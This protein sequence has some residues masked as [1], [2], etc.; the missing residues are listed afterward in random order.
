MTPGVQALL[1]KRRITFPDSDGR[2]VHAFPSDRWVILVTPSDERTARANLEKILVPK[3]LT[4]KDVQEV[5]RTKDGRYAIYQIP[6]VYLKDARQLTAVEQKQGGL[7]LAFP[8]F[9][10]DAKGTV[11]F[12]GTLT[13]R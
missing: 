4:A 13:D 2:V 12:T 5:N 3:F 1:G 10:C 9:E 8:M 11:I 7:P 6:R